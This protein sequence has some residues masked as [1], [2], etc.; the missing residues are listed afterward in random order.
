M[1]DETIFKDHLSTHPTTNLRLWVAFQM[2]KGAGWAGGI[3]FAILIGI[4]FWRV[5]GR[6][7]GAAEHGTPAPNITGSIDSVVQVISQLV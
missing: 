6:Y 3:F 1:A 5:I 7:L 2:M 4:G